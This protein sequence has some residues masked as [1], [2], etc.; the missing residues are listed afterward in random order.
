MTAS[1]AAAVMMMMMM[2]MMKMMTLRMMS[3]ATFKMA[4]VGKR[5]PS[6]IRLL[7]L[8]SMSSPVMT[9]LMRIIGWEGEQAAGGAGEEE[10][11]AGG[12]QEDQEAADG[13]ILVSASG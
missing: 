5:S 1:A 7:I 3:M 6:L 9:L 13:S 8:T 12:D 4:A 10:E 11:A 2:M